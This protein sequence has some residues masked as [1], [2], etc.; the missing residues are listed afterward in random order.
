M[1]VVY[2][3]GGTSLANA[4]C[5]QQVKDIILASPDRVI[6]VVSA[7]V[8]VT[9]DLVAACKAAKTSSSHYLA[10]LEE[11]KA[12]HLKVAADL[13]VS[14]EVDAVFEDLKVVLKSVFLTGQLPCGVENYVIGHGEVFSMRLL[15]A[16]MGERAKALDARDFLTIN[17]A[18]DNIL[19]V[20]WDESARRLATCAQYDSHMIM[21]GFICRTADGKMATLRRNGSD[22][23]ASIIAKLSQAK[24][25][26]IWKDVNGVL[27]ADP[28]IVANARLVPELTYD[29][30]AELTY[31]GA[32]VLHP[33][34]MV[35]AIECNIPIYVK[36]TSQPTLTGTVIS[37]QKST[38]SGLAG[39]S[40]VSKLAIVNVGGCAMLGVPDIAEKVFAAVK[41][42]ASNVYL[43][44]QASSG[45]SLSFVV[46][47]SEADLVT[48]R[49]KHGL[50]RE[51][52]ERQLDRI[53]VI[54]PVAILAC[55]GDQL[56]HWIGFAARF[57][58]AIAECRVNIIAIAQ[59][60]SERNLTIVVNEEDLHTA[61]VSVH[62][63]FYTDT[64][65]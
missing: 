58:T 40:Y 31:F 7:I 34:T 46:L 57:F 6:A 11:I 56:R 27:S 33:L 45:H 17:S 23:S 8:G 22:Y 12:K 15:T 30:A 64:A 18:D 60:S 47:A 13:E 39:V 54:R 37:S 51:I 52:M 26:T 4:E 48:E 3:F 41:L 19:Q 55:V 53:T 20:L 43:I 35:P 36:N 28:R 49:I 44:S 25:L 1:S 16:F 21:T 10:I 61:L 59:D 29:E 50:Y 65:S 63:C 32:K 5:F 42:V 62:D 9:D 14:L 24:S 38:Q 2:K